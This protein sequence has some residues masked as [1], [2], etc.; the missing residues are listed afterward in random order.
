M[1]LRQLLEEEAIR[2]KDPQSQRERSEWVSS[3]MRL[4]EQIRT[5]LQE[6]DREQIL[7]I[8]DES[9]TLSEEGYGTYNIPGLTVRLGS[10]TVRVIPVAGR[11]AGPLR[12]TGKI[13]VIRVDGRVDLVGSGMRFMLFR[14]AEGD[15]GDRWA[16]VEEDSLVMEPFDQKAFER[17]FER[18]LR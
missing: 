14:Q 15:G 7:T 3:V 12:G 13:A 6:A 1:S 4:V 2:Q 8:W 17:T 16:L 10:R 5:W 11:V 18:L 9:H